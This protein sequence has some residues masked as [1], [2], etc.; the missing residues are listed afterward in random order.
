M[1][2]LLPGKLV[3]AIGNDLICVHIRLRA[4]TGL[5]HDEGK[6]RVQRAGND[7]ITGL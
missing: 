3:A 5:P 1:K 4:G 7:L 6:M 2:E